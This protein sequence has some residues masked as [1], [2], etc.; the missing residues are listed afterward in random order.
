VVGPSSG[1][2]VER[3]LG[4]LWTAVAQHHD[5]AI[6]DVRM[7]PGGEDDG[8]VTAVEL[9]TQHPQTGVLLLSQHIELHH[10]RPLLGSAGFGYLLKESVLHLDEFDLALHRVAD[11]G[12]ALDPAVVQALVQSQSTPAIARLSQRDMRCSISSPKDTQTPEWQDSSGSQTG[13]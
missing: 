11:G 8:A 7:P 13:Q 6:V 3:H 12:I 5:L 2:G 9:R 10:C 4:P 1:G